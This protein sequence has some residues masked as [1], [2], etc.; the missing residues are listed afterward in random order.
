[1]VIDLRHC[2]VLASTAPVDWADVF[3][4]HEGE[5]ERFGYHMIEDRWAYGS[6]PIERDYIRNRII[7]ATRAA[8]DPKIRQRI[9]FRLPPAGMAASSSKGLARG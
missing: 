5:Y 6:E 9:R 8:N 2:L 3:A 4:L 7:T 1:M